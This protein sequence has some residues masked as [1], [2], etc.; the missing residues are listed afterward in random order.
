M[1][2]CVRLAKERGRAQEAGSDWGARCAPAS[3]DFGWVEVIPLEPSS[4]ANEP[5]RILNRQLNQPDRPHE[6]AHRGFDH[7]DV[8]RGAARKRVL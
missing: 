5:N 1:I 3:F 2:V 6:Q 7:D 8:V 4:I